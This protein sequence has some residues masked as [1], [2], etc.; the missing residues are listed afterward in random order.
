[1]AGTAHG[2][3]WSWQALV[4][5]GTGHGRHWSW[6]VLVMAGTGHG[7]HWSWQALV[8]AG[9]GHGRHIMEVP[10]L[11]FHLHWKAFYVDVCTEV[12][13]QSTVDA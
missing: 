1:M 10:L 6:Q 7:R 3:H 8:M 11:D 5:A 13:V 2:R 4:M 12:K 9:T